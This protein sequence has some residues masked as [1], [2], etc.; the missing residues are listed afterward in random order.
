M[1]SLKSFKASVKQIFGQLQNIYK[2]KSTLQHLYATDYRLSDVVLCV[3]K[4]DELCNESFKV[5]TSSYLFMSI[6]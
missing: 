6:A 1:C 4:L 5:A 3:R 2:A